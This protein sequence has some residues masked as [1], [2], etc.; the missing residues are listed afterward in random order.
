M[1][2]SQSIRVELHICPICHRHVEWSGN[3]YGYL[4]NGPVG[5]RHDDAEAEAVVGTFTPEAPRAL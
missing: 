5:Q 3:D 2:S 1:P 4:C